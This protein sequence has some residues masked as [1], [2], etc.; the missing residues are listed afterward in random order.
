MVHAMTFG[1]K[2]RALLTEQ[3]LSLRKLAKAIPADAGLL[4]KISRDLERPSE[5]MAVL[6]DEVLGAGGELVALRPPTVRERLDSPT[7][8]SEAVSPL[9]LFGEA[10]R[11]P[12]GRPAD[13]AYVESI[14]ETS[15]MLV[16]LDAL[17]GAH[18]VLPLALCAFRKA[19]HKL[20]TGAYGLGVERDLMAAAG[21]CG[22]IAAWLAYD[23]DQQDT[24]RHLIHEA[25]MLSREAG[26]RSMEHFQL[27]H[28]AMQSLHLN[29]SAEALRI[30]GGVLYAGDLPPRVKVLFVMRRGRALAQLGAARAAFDALD[31][32]EAALADSVVTRDPYWTWWLDDPEII[33]HK[34]IA[35]TELGQWEQAI[36]LYERVAADDRKGVLYGRLPLA[37]LLDAL[38]R[39][40]DWGRTEEVLAQVVSVVD[41]QPGRAV[42]LLRRIA[43]KIRAAE[44]A[45]STVVDMAAYLNEVLP[46]TAH[47]DGGSSS[48]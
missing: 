25:L 11:T 22:E 1:E 44:R 38:V 35:H 13:T 17:H 12:N 48:R 45:P 10:T 41:P 4:S 42:N 8:V 24:S 28:M 7:P 40:G 34:A 37:M 16:R 27:S 18:A 43:P 29:R 23:A 30:A 36:P 31:Q 20:G 5:R 21:E 2:M 46:R 9:E 15:Q 39:V 32:A 14:R 6:I 19:G 3:G 33:W 47:G 26:D